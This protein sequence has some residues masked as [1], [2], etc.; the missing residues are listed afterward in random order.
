MMWRFLSLA[1]GCVVLSLLGGCEVT[2][3]SGVTAYE[4]ERSTFVPSKQLDNIYVPPRYY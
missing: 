2:D 3:Q 4:P 1:V